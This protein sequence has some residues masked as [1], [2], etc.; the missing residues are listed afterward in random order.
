M[1]STFRGV[2]SKNHVYTKQ[3]APLA[4]GDVGE[5][6]LYARNADCRRID[7]SAPLSG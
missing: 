2:S 6:L 3:S 1:N 7:M 4:L 5:R